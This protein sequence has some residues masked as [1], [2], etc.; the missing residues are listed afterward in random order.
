MA[1]LEQCRIAFKVN[2]DS[3]LYREK[4]KGKA[5][6]RRI[7]KTLA[8]DSGIPLRTL[9]RWYKEEEDKKCAKIGADRPTKQKD[10]KND[11]SE[12]A[13]AAPPEI[14]LRCKKYPVYRRKAYGKLQP[15]GPDS[16]YYGLCSNCRDEQ[17]RATKNNKSIEEEFGRQ[18]VCPECHHVFPVNIEG[19]GGTL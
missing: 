18:V 2:A 5:T 11:K 16:K 4:Q 3:L 6:V 17:Y 10:L 8:R 12:D 9:Q 7:L 19:K 13:P 1:W 14:C 15:L